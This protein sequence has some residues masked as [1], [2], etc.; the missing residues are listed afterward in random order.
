MARYR[1]VFFSFKWSDVTRAEVV[2]NSYITKGGQQAARYID[3]AQ[4]EALK[5]QTDLAIKRWINQQMRGTTVTV[6]LVGEETSHSRW[7]RYEVERTL[8]EH[9]GL[10]EVDI[11]GIADFKGRTSRCCG[12]LTP[13]AYPRY[14]WTADAGYANLGSWVEMA[15]R[16]AG[17]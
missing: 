2:R 16:K 12:R 4:R 9:H 11:S 6:V 10:I 15:A 3:V 14:S 8:Q 17:Y 13:I 1:N 7:V 5:R